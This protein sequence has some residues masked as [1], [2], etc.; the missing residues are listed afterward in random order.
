MADRG[1]DI[2]DTLPNR[3]TLNIP[4]FK[5]QRGQLTV[6]ETEETAGMDAVRIQVERT[7]GRIKHYHI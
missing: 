1:F 2:Q 5:G 4:P 7:I 6:K 3:V